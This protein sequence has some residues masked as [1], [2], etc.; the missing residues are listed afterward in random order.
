MKDKTK[1]INNGEAWIRKFIAC[2]TT[3]AFFLY[4]ALVTFYPFNRPL[5]ME[6]INLAMGWIGGVATS[7]ITFYF[8]SSS[9]SDEKN[10]IISKAIGNNTPP[11]PSTS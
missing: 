7:V 11:P 8:G 1:R 10:S 6:F 5:N 9:G 3:V 4:I 2:V